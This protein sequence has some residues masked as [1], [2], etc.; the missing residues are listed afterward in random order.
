MEYR[1]TNSNYTNHYGFVNSQV[2]RLYLFFT[3]LYFPSSQELKVE[4]IVLLLFQSLQ[5]TY[6]VDTAEIDWHKIIQESSS[7]ASG[8]LS[9]DVPGQGSTLEL[10]SWQLLGSSRWGGAIFPQLLLLGLLEVSGW[11]LWETICCTRWTFWF[12]PAGLMLCSYEIT[13]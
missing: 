13:R 3:V 4:Y 8:D 6:K 12:G 7:L 2:Q 11:L 5:Q 9:L 1:S 10:P